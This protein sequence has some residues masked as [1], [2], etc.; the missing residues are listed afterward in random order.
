MGLQ[1][2]YCFYSQMAEGSDLRSNQEDARRDVSRIS[3]PQGRGHYRRASAPG[4]CSSYV[5]EDSA[6]IRGVERRGVSEREERDYDRSMF[7]GEGAEFHGR[8][9]LGQRLLCLH[10]GIG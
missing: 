10:G 9:L 1:V 2:S 6:E 7:C 8:E 4:S 3:Q 5:F